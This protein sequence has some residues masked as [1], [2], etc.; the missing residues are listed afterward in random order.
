MTRWF[1]KTKKETVNLNWI[2]KYKEGRLY[3]GE[4]NNTGSR[5]GILKKS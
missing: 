4:K 2:L 5:N 1:G 3:E